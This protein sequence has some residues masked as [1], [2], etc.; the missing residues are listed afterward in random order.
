[1]ELRGD[2]PKVVD[3]VLELDNERRQ[4][5]GKTEEMKARRN[6]VSEEIAEKKRN[7]ENADDVIKE[8]RELGDEI[9]ENDAKLNEVDNK[10]RDI[11][12]R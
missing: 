6:K 7:K 8:M 5:I 4:L 10:V 1:M 9:K 11:L 2:D 3:E 12:I